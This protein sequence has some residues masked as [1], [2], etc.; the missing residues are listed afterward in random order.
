MAAKKLNSDPLFKHI[1]QEKA[2]EMCFPPQ[3]LNKYHYFA[4]WLL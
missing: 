4:D 3:Y 1:G 2:A